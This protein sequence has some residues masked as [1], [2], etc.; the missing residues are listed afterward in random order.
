MTRLNRVLTG[1]ENVLAAGSLG[2]AALIAIVA[3]LV[4]ATTGYVIFWSEEAVIHLVITSTFLGAVVALRHGEHVG[5]DVLTPLMRERGRRVLALI[6][7]AVTLV[8]LALI[9]TFAWLVLAEPYARLTVTP[10]IG[11]PLWLVTLPVP[12]GLTLMFVR[13]IEIAVRIL[14]GHDPYPERTA[15]TE[16]GEDTASG[17]PGVV[18]D[19]RAARAEGE[20]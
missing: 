11:A 12:I 9:G 3:V 4:R 6:G 8:Y 15:E 14:R 17:L 10:A 1:T 13:A 18:A 19:G 16:S 7:T 20:R 2:L 5:V